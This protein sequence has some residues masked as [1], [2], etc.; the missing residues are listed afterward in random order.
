MEEAHARYRELVLLL[1]P[2]RNPALDAT[3]QFQ[4][5]QQEYKDLPVLLKYLPYLNEPQVVYI[6][7]PVQDHRAGF[8]DVVK[9]VAEAIP[10]EGYA[11]GVKMMAGLFTTQE[12]TIQDQN[13]QQ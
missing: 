12:E 8:W 11:E 7:V 10:P 9:S 5:M 13:S 6:P 3:A 4:E 2:D 1:H